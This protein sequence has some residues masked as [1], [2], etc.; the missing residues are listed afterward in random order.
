MAERPPEALESARATSRATSRRGSSRA[1]SEAGSSIRAGGDAGRELLDRGPAAE[2]DRQPAHGPRAQRLDPGPAR[3]G[4]RACA[5]SARSGS[6]A[7]TTPASRRSAWSSSSSSPRASRARRSGA[8]RSSSA[9]GSGCRSTATTSRASSSEL[10]ASLDYEDERFT[11]DDA[12]RARGHEGVRAPVREGARLPRQLHGQL[13]PRPAHRHLGPRGRAAQR[14]GHALLDRL[15]ARVRLGLGDGRDGAPGDDAGRHRD[16]G[17]PVRRALLAA[18]RARPRS[19]RSWAA[20]CRSSPTT[21]STP[22]S[23][24][25][26]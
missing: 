6:S 11:M 17:E 20:G 14:R 2:R 15:P 18:D 24:P 12:L 10:G 26:P 21:T 19:C 8:R 13:G 1:G 5:G 22:S 25:A 4:S 23:A 3:S 9:S 16:R 7:R